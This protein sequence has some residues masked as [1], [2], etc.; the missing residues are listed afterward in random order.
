MTAIIDFMTEAESRW[1]FKYEP[2]LGPAPDFG[3]AWFKG[4][5]MVRY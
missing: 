5:H 1:K 3:C 4:S 2:Q